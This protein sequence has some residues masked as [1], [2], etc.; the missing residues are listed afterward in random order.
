MPGQSQSFSFAGVKTGRLAGV[1][2]QRRTCCVHATRA[3]RLERQRKTPRGFPHDCTDAGQILLRRRWP[4][5][6]VPRCRPWPAVW[7]GLTGVGQLSVIN[8]QLSTVINRT[9]ITIW[10]YHNGSIYVCGTW[11]SVEAFSISYW[12]LKQEKQII[13]WI[14]IWKTILCDNV[15]F[16]YPHVQYSL[17]W[18]TY[19]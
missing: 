5:V 8:R 10:N 1:N 15:I 17:S 9:K 4:T 14:M 13:L 6:D 19:F 7:R 12:F 2:C 11:H 18:T 3:D 16:N